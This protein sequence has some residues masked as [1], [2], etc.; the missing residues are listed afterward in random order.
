[1]K[2]NTSN[3]TRSDKRTFSPGFKAEA[4]SLA[5][6]PG[7][8]IAKVAKDLDVA[9]G[10]LRNWIEQPN[11]MHKDCSLSLLTA[12]K[13]RRTRHTSTRTSN[14]GEYEKF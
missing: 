12:S 13:K 1:M 4:V 11:A 14:F 10:V 9:V 3:Q 8:S 6:K 2:P 5:R 7:H